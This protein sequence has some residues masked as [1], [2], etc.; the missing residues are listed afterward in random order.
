M[1]SRRVYAT[2]T[3]RLEMTFL[4]NGQWMGSIV[5]GPV[6]DFVVEMYDPD[7]PIK[8]VEMITNGGKV[9]EKLELGGLNHVKW[10][11]SHVP[12]PGRQWFYLRITHTNGA[13]AFS[14]PIFTPIQ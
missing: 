12:S 6:L 11:F 8:K 2:E 5:P 7:V 13:K 9:M 3:R 1:Q 14:S 10:N 4:A